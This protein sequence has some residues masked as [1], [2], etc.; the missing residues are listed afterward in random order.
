MAAHLAAA[1]HQHTAHLVAAHQPTYRL[2]VDAPRRCSAIFGLPLFVPVR[3]HHRCA[4]SLRKIS[5]IT[6]PP[7]A[8]PSP[9]MTPPMPLSHHHHCLPPYSAHS[10]S[11]LKTTAH[12][13]GALPSTR[14][15][16][17]SPPLSLTDH[18]TTD[19]AQA[20]TTPRHHLVRPPSFSYSFFPHQ[21]EK[22]KGA[23]TG[24]DA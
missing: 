12:F 9:P 3:S 20:T 18:Y 19:T 4:F 14:R 15:L 2:T 23:V 16:G 17:S 6:R 22:S 21:T 1:I 11:H 13:T 8:S 10:P 24:I 5:A 7:L